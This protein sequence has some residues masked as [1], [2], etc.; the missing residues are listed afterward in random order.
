[1]RSAVMGSLRMLGVTLLTAAAS[2]LRIE[3][4]RPARVLAVSSMSWT[5]FSAMP[6]KYFVS[7]RGL[8]A[9]G[10]AVGVGWS[11]IGGFLLCEIGETDFGVGALAARLG[12]F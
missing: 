12:G 9:A 3:R 2:P 5:S 8:G 7:A 1:M 10:V 4:A 6:G 11:D